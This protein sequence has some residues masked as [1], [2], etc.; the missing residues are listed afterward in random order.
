SVSAAVSIRRRLIL[1]T[2][3]KH[4]S[5]LLC[6]PGP[7]TIAALD[8]STLRRAGFSAGKAAT[9]RLLASQVAAQALPFQNWLQTQPID[10]IRDRLLAMRG[11]GPWTVNYT[12]LRGF[13]WLD[14]SLHGDVAV[15][16]AIEALQGGTTTLSDK[17]AQAWLAAFTP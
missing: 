6:H 8:D 11:I 14:G 12:L 10:D 4:S 17:Q 2:D 1:A 7:E 16:R 15:R 13:G 3:L 9:L 5:G